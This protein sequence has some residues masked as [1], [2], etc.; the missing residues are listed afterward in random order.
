M[1]LLRNIE[2]T[3]DELMVFYDMWL[4]VNFGIK[5]SSTLF[6]LQLAWSFGLRSIIHGLTLL[7][8]CSTTKSTGV[9]D[10]MPASFSWGHIRLCL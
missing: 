10:A 5:H 1:L 3:L 4:D 9:V 7:T 6:V 8:I 2:C